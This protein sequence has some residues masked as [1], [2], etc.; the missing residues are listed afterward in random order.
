MYVRTYNT[1][2][3]VCKI[4][5]FVC[6]FLKHFSF[7]S[8]DSVSSVQLL[9]CVQLFV[10]PWTAAHQ[11]SQSFPNSWSLIK[12]MSIQ[13]VMPSNHLILN[14]PFSSCFQTSSGSG[15]FPMSWLFALGGQ[16]I[17]VSA[18]VIPMNIQD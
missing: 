11:A 7:H 2:P 16:S 4:V 18:S 10:I 12:F 5:A 14:H 3:Q 1:V 9:S 6:F 8:S 13:L 17:G 15:S